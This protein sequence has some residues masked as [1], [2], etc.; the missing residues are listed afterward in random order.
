MLLLPYL[1]LPTVLTSQCVD[2]N[3]TAITGILNQSYHDNCYSYTHTLDNCCQYFLQNDHCQK[4]YTDCSNY[5]DYVLN[6]LYNH[7]H[8]HNTTIMDIPYSDECHNFTLHMEPYCCDNLTHPDCLNYYTQCHTYNHTGD[9]ENC[10]IPYNLNNKYCRSYTEQIDSICCDQFD[11]KCKQIYNWCLENNPQHVTILDLFIGPWR[12]H[13][14]GS[15]L[16]VYNNIDSLEDCA[17]LCLDTNLCRSFDYTFNLNHCHLAYHVLGDIVNGNEVML[18]KDPNYHT[19][20]YEKILSMPFDNS[21]CNVQHPNW[22][23]DGI[24]DKKGGYNTDRCQYD[25]GDCCS[26]TCYS[27]YCGVFSYQCLDPVVLYPNSSAPTMTPTTGEPTQTPTGEPTLISTD[28]PTLT[29]TGEPTLTPTGEPTL[30]P[31]GEPTLTPTGEPTL[32]PTGEPTQEPTLTPTEEPTQEP[33]NNQPIIMKSESSNNNEYGSQIYGAVVGLIVLV[34][35][36]FVILGIVLLKNREDRSRS[37][38]MIIRNPTYV[39]SNTT[40]T[41]SVGVAQNNDNISISDDEIGDNSDLYD[42]PVVMEGVDDLYNNE[43]IYK[44]EELYKDEDE[45]YTNSVYDDDNYMKIDSSRN[46]TGDIDI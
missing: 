18:E 3:T 2:I 12:G 46:S 24:C 38:A 34:C 45:E 16:M 22:I 39:K 7:C 5:E 17:Q 40:T 14:V 11:R 25:G 21:H 28:E 31:T 13:T 6:N 8:S 44:D 29:P 27:W 15:S 37:K 41:T 23:G 43:A 42:E 32:T 1:L 19:F 26:E 30:T 4:T 10:G 20:Y 35:I 9:D 33:T 36:L